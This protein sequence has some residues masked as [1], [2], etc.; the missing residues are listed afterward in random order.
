[1]N[2]LFND[3]DKE[4]RQEEKAK[5]IHRDFIS[6][7]HRQFVTYLNK[8]N[9]L[10][11]IDS[12]DPEQGFDYKIYKDN[13]TLYRI[14]YDKFLKNRDGLKY[15]LENTCKISSKDV[16]KCKIIDKKIKELMVKRKD[17]LK[18][19]HKLG[20]KLTEFEYERAGTEGALFKKLED[21]R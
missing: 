5:K 3:I 21:S 16:R 8:Y 7:K 20:E 12:L 15:I 2:S 9:T 14:H 11:L 6:K 17:I 13:E 1:M 4:Y 10:Y 19:S 18:K